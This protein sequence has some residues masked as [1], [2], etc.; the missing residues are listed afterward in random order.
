M[1]NQSS[2]AK[3]VSQEIADTEK[4]FAPVVGIKSCKKMSGLKDIMEPG[5]E[6]VIWQRTLP[7]EFRQW[8]RQVAPICLPHLQILVAPGD[9]R[10]ALEP[11]LDECGL[12]AGSMRE[13]M[14][15]DI[16]DLVNAFA[17]IT[18]SE[19]VDLRLEHIDHDACWRFHI[20]IVETRLLTTYLG[21]AT[22]WVQPV[23]AEQ[24]INEQKNFSGPIER[25]CRDDVAI[26]KGGNA[27]RG[28]GIVHR[29]PR[30]KGTGNKRLLLCLNKQ[31]EVSPDPWDKR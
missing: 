26:F 21:P 3:L 1:L 24:A 4:S 25:L 13:L 15:C 22:E 17:L 20:D 30:L 23:Y 8:I 11:M 6:L 31:S 5:T 2:T 19:R 7:T 18:G 14:V 16:T 9:L 28:S 12:P 27:A 10:S 29:S